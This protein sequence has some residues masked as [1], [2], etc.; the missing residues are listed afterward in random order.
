M[1]PLEGA[2]LFE[3]SSTYKA[4]LEKGREVGRERGARAMRQSCVALLEARLGNL[5][6]EAQVLDQITDLDQL[7]RL[8]ERLIKAADEGEMLTAL[9]EVSR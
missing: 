6:S 3:E 9:R 4:I 1:P 2:R 8:S 5:P 7:Q